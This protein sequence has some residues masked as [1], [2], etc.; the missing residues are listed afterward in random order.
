MVH[1]P[2]PR[3]A[4]SSYNDA[5]G[6]P[7]TAVFDEIKHVDTDGEFWLGRELQPLLGYEE[8]R[9][10]ADAIA[11]AEAAIQ[12][13]GISAAQHV[14][15]LRQAVNGFGPER[16]DYR[17][18]RY[19]AY[20]VAMNGDPRKPEVAAAQ[21]YFAVKAREAEVMQAQPALPTSYAQ[22]L[23]ELAAEVEAREAA[24][25]ALAIAAPKVAIADRFLGDGELMYLDDFA[26]TL[27]LT[28]HRL[29]SIL[30]DEQVLYANELLYRKGYEDWFEVVHDWVPQLSK[31]MPALKVTRA[32]VRAIYELLVDHEWISGVGQ[33]VERVAGQRPS[34]RSDTRGPGNTRP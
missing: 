28:R 11:R 30:R 10:F 19:G 15:Q 34:A 32:G 33:D 22:A 27:K 25:T 9:R 1:L 21:T 20:M 12:N 18:T 7:V 8:W 14:C 24:E 2:R 13:T 3:G 31:S 23:R 26:K 29:V 16:V 4:S 5:T 17:L 6:S